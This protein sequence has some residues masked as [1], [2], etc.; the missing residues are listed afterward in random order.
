MMLHDEATVR[1]YAIKDPGEAR[2]RI[3]MQGKSDD[4]ARSVLAWEILADMAPTLFNFWPTSP[5]GAGTLGLLVRQEAERPIPQTGDRTSEATEVSDGCKRTES[6]RVRCRRSKTRLWAGCKPKFRGRSLSSNRITRRRRR[7]S[8]SSSSALA[9][10]LLL[11]LPRLDP[12]RNLDCASEGASGGVAGLWRPC[13]RRSRES[14]LYQAPQRPW[15]R[16]SVWSADDERL[17]DDGRTTAQQTGALADG[18]WISVAINQ[19]ASDRGGA[20]HLESTA[21]RLEEEEHHFKRRFAREKCGGGGC[22]NRSIP[23]GEVKLFPLAKQTHR[24]HTL[25]P[26]SVTGD[27]CKKSG[28]AASM[29][30]CLD[31]VATRAS[32]SSSGGCTRVC[33]LEPWEGSQ[34]F[35]SRLRRQSGSGAPTGKIVW[36]TDFQTH[37]RGQQRGSKSDLHSMHACSNSISTKAERY[38]RPTPSTPRP[39]LTPQAAPSLFP[40]SPTTSSDTTLLAPTS[41]ASSSSSS[42]SSSPPSSLASSRASQVCSDACLSADANPPAENGSLPAAGYQSP[43]TSHTSWHFLEA[44]RLPPRHDHLREAPSCHPLPLCCS[45][46]HQILYFRICPAFPLRQRHPCHLHKLH[47]L[48]A[49]PRSPHTLS[50]RTG[51]PNCPAEK[52]A[53]LSHSPTWNTSSSPVSNIPSPCTSQWCGDSSNLVLPAPYRPAT[54]HTQRASPSCTATSLGMDDQDDSHDHHLVA[55]S[56]SSSQSRGSS[57]VTIRGSDHP[58]S[59]PTE[60]GDLPHH[61][62]EDI[63][64]TPRAQSPFFP[65]SLSG[66]PGQQQQQQHTLDQH[67]QHTTESPP[68]PPSGPHT[69]PPAREVLAQQAS[70]MQASASTTGPLLT[71]PSPSR[72]SLNYTRKKLGGGRRSSTRIY[73]DALEE[74]PVTSNADSTPPASIPVRLASVPM[75]S[76]EVAASPTAPPLLEAAAWTDQLRKSLIAEGLPETAMTAEQ[77]LRQELRTLV[78]PTRS[79]SSHGDLASEFREPLL[80]S[81]PSTAAAAGVEMSS[82][83]SAS[84][85]SD[86]SRT[87]STSTAGSTGSMAKSHASTETAPSSVLSDD[88][89]DTAEGADATERNHSNSSSASKATVGALADSTTLIADEKYVQSKLRRYHA[90]VELVETERSYTNDLAIL[91]LVY[92]EALPSQPFF[93]DHPARIDTVVRNTPELLAVHS[94]IVAQLESILEREG[95]AVQDPGSDTDKALSKGVDNAIVAVGDIFA[96]IDQQLL[97]YH[98]FC[99]RH[100]EA[101]SV[102]REAEKRH[103][104]EDFAQ[105]ERMC[106]NVTRSRPGSLSSKNS[107]TTEVHRLSRAPSFTTMT[108]TGPGLRGQSSLST[109]TPITSVSPATSETGSV[110]PTPVLPDFP[111]SRQGGR[112]NFQDLL[113]KPVQRLCLYPLVLHTLLKHTGPDD[114]GKEELEAAL[115]TVRR[116]ADEVDEAGKRRE[117]FLLAELVASRVEA[118]GQVTRNLLSSY[119]RVYLSGTLDV[120]YHHS[121]YAT[122]VAPLRFRFLGL[123]LY[124]GWLLITKVMKSGS[125]EPRYWFPLYSAQLSSVEEEEGVLPHAFRLTVGEEHHFELAASSSRERALWVDALSTAISTAPSVP[126]SSSSSPSSFPSNFP[127]NLYNPG[128]GFD[129]PGSPGSGRVV[130]VASRPQVASVLGASDGK[131]GNEDPLN[132]FLVRH[133]SSP[134]SSDV[135]VRYASL[136]QRAV[137]DK[138]MVFSDSVLAARAIT[139]KDGT[140][141]PGGSLTRTGPQPTQVSS[142]TTAPVLASWQAATSTPQSSL[143]AAVGAAMGLARAAKR[144]STKSSTNVFEAAAQ[145]YLAQEETRMAEESKTGARDGSRTPGEDGLPMQ[146]SMLGDAAASPI[147]LGHRRKRSSFG[148]RN[149]LRPMSTIF[150]DFELAVRTSDTAASPSMEGGLLLGSPITSTASPL[151]ESALLPASPTSLEPP[152]PQSGFARKRPGSVYGSSLRDAF[153]RKSRSHSV[154]LST[155]AA[156]Q[157]TLPQS[158]SRPEFLPLSAQSSPSRAD[159]Q[160]QPAGQMTRNSSIRRAF[161]NATSG[162]RRERASSAGAEALLAPAIGVTPASSPGKQDQVARAPTLPLDVASLGAVTPGKRRTSGNFGSTLGI[163]GPPFGNIRRSFAG[164]RNGGSRD[165]SRRSSI[166]DTSSDASGSISSASGV[167]GL[168]SSLGDQAEQTSPARG[169]LTVADG[170]TGPMSNGDSRSSLAPSENDAILSS[171]ERLQRS[172]TQANPP[173]D[174]PTAMPRTR[175]TPLHKKTSLSSL[176]RRGS[177]R[178]PSTTPTNSRDPTTALASY[179]ASGNVFSNGGN[180]SGSSSS[181]SSSSGSGSSLA[182]S[183]SKRL[184]ASSSKLSGTYSMSKG[185]SISV[186]GGDSPGKPEVPPALAEEEGEIATPDSAWSFRTANA[187]QPGPRPAATDVSPNTTPMN[188]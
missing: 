30:R 5:N 71:T 125:Y 155:A 117:H 129:A 31:V 23:P 80:A 131:S 77:D 84:H 91:V 89:S 8:S 48:F 160:G 120:L 96:T 154:D 42:S 139:H 28:I 159:Q 61:S 133:I 9:R 110:P 182:R 76:P 132:N 168:L 146:R 153:S 90:L 167:P 45:L 20:A 69:P 109:I 14:S 101:L 165:S 13:S 141:T 111:T 47:R 150:P 10:T 100:A 142:P 151:E 36:E 183:L 138:G 163:M 87:P 136:A 127:S 186:P 170:T 126:E 17:Q 32:S 140:F 158:P 184:F 68:P 34:S 33:N 81:S 85:V 118:K 1:D 92:L 152:A 173:V 15:P 112:L 104:G 39:L 2:S 119:G 6:L 171:L 134:G 174:R 7:R 115:A 144:S 67:Q 187:S 102:I 64:L 12:R 114:A 41:P 19:T 73:S 178:D 116:V 40:S 38:L 97:P 57:P 124:H 103:N 177:S 70:P 95:I 65:T 43:L 78:V 122:L 179:Q 22:D 25:P 98:D 83:I 108:P 11:S 137:V 145:Q 62:S 82:S 106:S 147:K 35:E 176:R 44:P 164:F 156:S 75:A 143:G 172:Q 107:S 94:E 50:S 58:R 26:P 59:S 99:A 180:S 21:A 93:E 18:F 72:G 49:L 121:T 135:I 86:I 46:Q 161:T 55:P 113:I 188:E 148:G 166:A 74:A 63:F 162:S 149:G 52:E 3:Q 66:L 4:D 181:A 88:D 60:S 128:L 51:L 37:G 175:S 130:E 79:S 185:A 24:M 16:K 56:R 157:T 169:S 29:S 54:G 123:F 105:F 27:E 53:L